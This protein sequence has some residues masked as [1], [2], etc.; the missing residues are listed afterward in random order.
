MMPSQTGLA[1]DE[2]ITLRRTTLPLDSFTA[3]IKIYSRGRVC[4]EDG[5][6]WGG[7]GTGICMIVIK[8]EWGHDTCTMKLYITDAEME[9]ECVA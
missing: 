3:L 5:I 9:R 7:C 4:M 1:N 6:E 8:N 2:S